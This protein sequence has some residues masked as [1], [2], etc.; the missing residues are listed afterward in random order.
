M[1]KSTVQGVAIVASTVI[2]IGVAAWVSAERSDPQFSTFADDTGTVGTINVAGSIDSD[3]PFFQSLGTNGRTC[4]TCH[5]AAD[6]WTVT[7]AHLRERF[8]ASRGL[9]P[10]FSSNDGSHCEGAKPTSSLAQR[11]AASS[12]LLTKGLIRVGL[13]VP[14]DA[15]FTV[16]AVHDPHGCS[17]PL[18]NVMVLSST[19]LQ[20]LSRVMSDG[21]EMKSG[22][23]ILDDLKNQAKAATLGHAQAS[24][25]PTTAEIDAIVSFELGLFTAQAT[26]HAVGTLYAQGP[27]RGPAELSR[28]PFF[29]GINDPIGGNPT[30][31][32]FDL[33]AFTLFDRWMPAKHDEEDERTEAR[34]AI[35]RGESLFN[36]TPIVIT[37]VAGWNDNPAVGPSFKGTCTTC[38]DTPNSGNH[39]VSAPLNLGLTDASKRTPDLPLDTLRNKLTGDDV[40]TSDPDRPMISGQWQDVSKFTGAILRGLAARASY[41]H[42]GSAATLAEAATF[43]TPGF[44]SS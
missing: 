16:A 14:F 12:L 5:R 10:I 2:F 22:R 24:L 17:G 38:H 27:R 6:G 34:A 33:R 18:E 15:E 25:T 11:R 13:T 30:G 19:N 4:A 32:A 7:P 28:Q 3:N 36:T 35:A 44:T 40:T 1:M 20:F 41:V 43:T 39:S 21:R 29:I 37:G 23:S 42:N 26:D 31:A 9:D 8:A